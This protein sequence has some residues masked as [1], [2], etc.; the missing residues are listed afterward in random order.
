MSESF[1]D[2]DFGDTVIEDGPGVLK[3][4]TRNGGV[5]DAR[6]VSDVTVV[7]GVRVGSGVRGVRGVRGVWGVWGVW[8]ALGVLGVRI[9]SLSLD[10]GAN[11]WRR[12]D[13]R[14]AIGLRI[15]GSRRSS[16]AAFS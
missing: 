7:R 3:E 10:A 16:I 15:G 13:E 9:T 2:L 1:S 12:V 4:R 8:G 6:R 5:S 14:M 11:P